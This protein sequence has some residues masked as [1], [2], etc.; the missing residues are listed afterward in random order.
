MGNHIHIFNTQ[1]EYEANKQ[2]ITPPFIAH[3]KENNKM[4][5]H[6]DKTIGSLFN[7]QRKNVNITENGSFTI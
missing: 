7:F 1:A 2:N 3:V 4:G 5:M 6:A